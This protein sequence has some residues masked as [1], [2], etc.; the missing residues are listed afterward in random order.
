M[1]VQRELELLIALCRYRGCAVF[2]GV[3]L[4]DLAEMQ[5]RRAHG[6]GA[7]S[8]GEVEEAEDGS[9]AVFGGLP[10]DEQNAGIADGEEAVCGCAEARE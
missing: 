8:S 10:G 4:R 2:Y 9:V 5:Q 6:D 7:L 3:G 1:G